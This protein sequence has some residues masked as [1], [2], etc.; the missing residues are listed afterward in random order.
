VLAGG[1]HRPDVGPLFFE[2][3]VLEGVPADAVCAR[4]ETF[5]P[6]VTVRRVGSDAEA[7]A[8]MNETEYGLNASVWTGDGRHGARVA[9]EVVAGTVSV[10]EAFI[11]SWG[12]VASPMGGRR[13]SGLGRRHGREGL[14]RFT[15]PQTIAVQRG[16]GFGVMYAQGSE[17]FTELFT[18]LLQAARVARLPWP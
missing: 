6:V 18:H 7:V 14:L 8:V 15:E 3:T 16:P 11:A 2:P 9:R 1:R 5:G 4:E 10:N 13:A 12:S 17:R